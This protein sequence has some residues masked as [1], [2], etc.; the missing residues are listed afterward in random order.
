M[1]PSAASSV[2]GGSGSAISGGAVGPMARKSPAGR[3]QSQLTQKCLF[4]L[5]P[6]DS[7]LNTSVFSYFLV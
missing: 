7:S 2:E 4:M 6:I 3:K 5:Y 1:T